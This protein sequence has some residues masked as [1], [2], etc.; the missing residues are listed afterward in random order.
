M[1]IGYKKKLASLMCAVVVAMGVQAQ[2]MDG[3]K[4][5]KG[6]WAETA[7]TAFYDHHYVNGNN[8][9]FYPDSPLTRE[10]A[11]AILNNMVGTNAQAPHIFS[12]MKGRWSEEAA[13]TLAEKHIMNGYTDKTFRPTEQ[14]DRE[15]FAVIA[16]NYMKYKGDNKEPTEPITFVDKEDISPWAEKAVQEL[17]GLGYIKGNNKNEFKPKELITRAQAV[18]ILYRIQEGVQVENSDKSA[19]QEAAFDEITRVYGS[20]K[21]FAKEGVMYWQGDKLHI[22]AKGDKKKEKLLEAIDGSDNVDLRN[23]VIVQEAKYGQKDYETM[24]NDIKEDYEKQDPQGKIL[25]IESDYVNEK[26]LLLIQEQD[27]AAQE[28]LKLKY[29]DV[30]KISTKK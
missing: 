24:M 9:Y 15:T 20:I 18:E 3:L 25:S 30:L 22:A 29:G 27:K 7:I 21:N 17:A 10:A 19:I 23:A 5:V 26:I 1:K 14:L 16:A 8:G 11:A 28:Y 2:D 13:A 4:D 6:H 12:D